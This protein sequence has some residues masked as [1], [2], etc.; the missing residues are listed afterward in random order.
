MTAATS[1]RGDRAGGYPRGREPDPAGGGRIGES[2]GAQD[3]PVEVPVAQ[4]GLGGGLRRDVGTR[5]LPPYLP[6]SPAGWLTWVAAS[7]SDSA[8][9]SAPSRMAMPAR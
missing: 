1:A 3:G 2:A 9:I 5:M 8:F 7:R 4:V 6:Q